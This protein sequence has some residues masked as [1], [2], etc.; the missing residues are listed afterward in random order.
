MDIDFGTLT[1]I[2]VFLGLIQYVFL[3]IIKSS[4][5]SFDI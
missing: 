2:L 5:P 1:I 4:R 3:T